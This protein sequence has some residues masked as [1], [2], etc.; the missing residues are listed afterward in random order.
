MSPLDTVIIVLYV[1]AGGLPLYAI[2]RGIWDHKAVTR[3]YKGY[4][5]S[6]YKV[7]DEGVREELKA[8]KRDLWYIG[9]GVVLASLAG[10]LSLV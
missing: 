2:L 7:S 3:K 9:G 10:V 5:L 4:G 8:R 1:A 6:D